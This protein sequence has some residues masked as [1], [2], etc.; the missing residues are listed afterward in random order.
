MGESS[1]IQKPDIVAADDKTQLLA[2]QPVNNSTYR[3]SAA[4]VR[5]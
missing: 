4:M 1:K 3:I 2:T 5:D